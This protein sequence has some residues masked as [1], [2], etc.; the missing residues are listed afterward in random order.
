MTTKIDLNRC[1][2]SDQALDLEATLSDKACHEISKNLWDLCAGGITLPTR[3]TAREVIRFLKKLPRVVI[4]QDG[5]RI[6]NSWGTA[7]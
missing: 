4:W 5:K 6:F 1:L 7:S 2:T 3:A